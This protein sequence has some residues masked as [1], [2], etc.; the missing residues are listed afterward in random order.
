MEG[1]QTKISISLFFSL[2][3]DISFA[4]IPICRI[5]IS[6]N[7]GEKMELSMY[8][9]SNSDFKTFTAGLVKQKE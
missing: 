3:R 1:K 9:K 5:D 8:F 6:Q 7:L 4:Q 2:E